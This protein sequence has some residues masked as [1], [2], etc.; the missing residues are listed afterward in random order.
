MDI[1]GVLIWLIAGIVMISLE[2]A[3]GEMTLLM[4]GLAALG[5]AGISL[6]DVPLWG[7]VTTFAVLSFASLF[8]LKPLL[9]RRLHQGPV[10]D[11]SHRSLIGSTAEVLEPVTNIQ[12]QVRLDGS[13][14]S[15]RSF[16]P[17]TQFEVGDLVNVMTIDGTTAIVWKES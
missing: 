14:W 1:V 13:I 3:V 7:E 11:T 10:L 4:L 6:F 9:R 15:A 12:G 16:D 2:L 8:F 17:E 5:T